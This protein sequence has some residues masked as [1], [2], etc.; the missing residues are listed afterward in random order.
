VL[1][2]QKA[3]LPAEKNLSSFSLAEMNN[4]LAVQQQKR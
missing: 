3:G 1:V 4:F 2:A